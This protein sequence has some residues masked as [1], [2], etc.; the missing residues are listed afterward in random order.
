MLKHF[1]NTGFRDFCV[2]VV[3]REENRQ[4]IIAGISGFLFFWSKSPFRDACVFLPTKKLLKPLFCSVLGVR[5]FWAK[6]SQ[7]KF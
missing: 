2:I 7:R 1:Q 5:A 3:E 4:K 6:L